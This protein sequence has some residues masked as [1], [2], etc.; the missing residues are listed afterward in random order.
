VLTHPYLLAGFAYT[1]TSSPIHRGVFVTRSVLGRR[2]N[3]PPEAVSP[4]APDLHPNLN[5]RERVTLQTSPTSCTTCH[6]MINPLGFGLEHVDAVGR[7]RSEEKGRPIDATGVLE[8]RTGESAPFN[9]A[10]E[11]AALLADS[12]EAHT[13]FVEQL[14][15]YLVKQPIRAFGPGTS[16]GLRRSFV[17]KKFNIRGLMVDIIAESAVTGPTSKSE[18][19]PDSRAAGT[20]PAAGPIA[21]RSED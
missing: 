14:F 15:H 21:T 19:G 1:A 9:G 3:P 8:T 17:E 5:T 13:A 11:L 6:T 2:L 20:P 18:P 7:Y 16:A 10:R 4:L 12:E